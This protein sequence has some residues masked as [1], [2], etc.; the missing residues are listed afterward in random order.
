[1]R[2]RGNAE[3]MTLHKSRKLG[4]L[5]LKQSGTADKFASEEEF[6][7]FFMR[8]REVEGDSNGFYQKY[9]EGNQDHQRA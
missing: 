6:I 7:R 4:C 1:M 3:H 2:K 5:S 8:N 9:Q